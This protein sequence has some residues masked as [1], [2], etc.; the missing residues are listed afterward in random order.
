MSWIGQLTLHYRR[1]GDQTLAHDRHMGPLRVLKRLYPE[2]PTICHHVL[3]HPPGGIVGGDILALEATLEPHTHALITT[4]GAT[5]FYRSTGAQAEQQVM[6]RLADGAR[7]EWLPLENIAYRG[8]RAENSMRFEL[9]PT[10]EMMGWDVVALGL[11][12]AGEAFDT[13]GHER[14]YF[15]QRIELPG[16]W[17]ERGLISAGDAALLD[18]PLGW[19]GRRV[20]GTL[21]FAAG[22]D[23]GQTRRHALVEA[24]RE[25]IDAAPPGL[26]MI[27]GV[28]AAHDEVV[29]L[30]VLAERV[31]PIATLQ[32]QVWARWRTL[33]WALPPCPSRVW[34]T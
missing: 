9:A 10:A 14:G 32:E 19:A 20:M 23:L 18:S 3:V 2:G 30:R 4:P 22:Q 24:A 5:R 28:T 31:E 16:L 6:A 17:L 26:G 7:L 34:R 15:G 13:P 21:W 25:L 27:A 8:C 11:P 12:S 1:E 29:V 33:G